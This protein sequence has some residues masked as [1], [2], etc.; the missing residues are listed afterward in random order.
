MLE[1]KVPL[2]GVCLGM[3][4]LFEESEEGPGDGLGVIPGR[5]RAAF[6]YSEFACSKRK[7]LNFLAAEVGVGILKWISYRAVS[8][9]VRAAGLHLV[10]AVFRNLHALRRN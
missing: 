8:S 9:V 7:S 5:V 6:L 4:L 2:L 10:Q 1:R 3:Q